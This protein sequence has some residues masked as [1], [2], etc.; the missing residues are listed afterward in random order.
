MKVFK[1]EGSSDDI[2][3][4]ECYDSAGKWITGDEMGV[5][6]DNSY[7]GYGAGCRNGRYADYNV[8][9]VATLEEAIKIIGLH[10]NSAKVIRNSL[11]Q[12]CRDEINQFDQLE[13]DFGGI[14]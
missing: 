1:F 7:T 11:A 3:G 8:G 12:M 4:Y 10:A 14:A 13:I 2:F 5:S 9:M 6:T